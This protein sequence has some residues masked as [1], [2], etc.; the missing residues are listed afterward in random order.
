MTT[1]PA[2]ALDWLAI[3]ALV[4]WGV[5]ACSIAPPQ[6]A[7]AQPATDA[8]AWTLARCVGLRELRERPTSRTPTRVAERPVA[9]EAPQAAPIRPE[10]LWERCASAANAA[11]HACLHNMLVS[12]G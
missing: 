3:A 6:F 11:R 5:A 1:A 4:G 12:C 9:P 10:G 8:A 7:L 2:R